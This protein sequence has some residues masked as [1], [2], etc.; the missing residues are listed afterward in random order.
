MMVLMKMMTMMM[1]KKKKRRRKK[2]NGVVVVVAVVV[3]TPTQN[4]NTYL[5]LLPFRGNIP[6]KKTKKQRTRLNRSAHGRTT[7]IK[8]TIIGTRGT[9][10]Y[11]TD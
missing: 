8:A 3:K 9:T 10:A 5:S 11:P 7:K 6:L 2:R 4:K 1:T